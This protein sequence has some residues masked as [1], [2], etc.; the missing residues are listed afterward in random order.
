M[1]DLKDM[2][3][4]KEAEQEKPEAEAPEVEANEAE[5][6]GEDAE[7]GEAEKDAAPKEDEK[8]KTPREPKSV[9]LAAFLEV[10]RKLEARLSEAEKRAA[11]AEAKSK[12]QPDYSSFLKKP[13]EKIPSV[14]DDENGYTEGLRETQSAELA[15]LKFQISLDNAVVTFGEDKVNGALLAFQQA[16]QNTPG[17]RQAAEAS[18]NPVRE[19][20]QW[21][22]A[23][24]KLS[25]AD[26]IEA[27]HLKEIAEAGGLEALKKALRVQIQKELSESAAQADGDDED[28]APVHKKPVMPSNFNKG[29][30]GGNKD[31]PPATD[32]KSLLA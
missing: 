2:L 30:K 7:G 19:I 28:D 11:D 16:A 12:A 25:Y 5:I 15:N 10:Q 4:G 9:P 26:R 17:L 8:P 23:Q 6:E 27:A 21:H 32:L 29:G 13:P 22:E 3:D 1:S 14:Y 24:Q 18:R 20:V 31:V